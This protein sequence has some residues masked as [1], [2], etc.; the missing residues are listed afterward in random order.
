MPEVTW[1]PLPDTDGA[2]SVEAVTTVLG[3]IGVYES[4]LMGP[5]LGQSEY[6]QA[7]IRTFFT[8]E[9]LYTD[10]PNLS[11]VHSMVQH[12]LGTDSQ[13]LN[14]P[15]LVLD[16][17][18]LNIL[19]KIE[20]WWKLIPPYTIITPHPGE[21]ARLCGISTADVQANRWELALQKAKEWRVILL[22]KGA[23]TA[24]ATPEGNLYILPFK[25]DALA[26]GGTGDILAGLIAGLLA[27]GAMPLHATVIGAY[28]QG[29]AGEIAYT[30]HHDGRSVIA[31]D[32]LACIAPAFGQINS[33]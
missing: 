32:I 25:N 3:K 22:L 19:A 10:K 29:L 21:M 18:A 8:H 33:L 16:A 1:L 31:S 2:I 15:N 24:I 30:Q 17:D 5:G 13:R 20:N 28:I 26:T 6:A 4:L 7:F 11:G 9:G 23:H 12:L 14:A 27:G